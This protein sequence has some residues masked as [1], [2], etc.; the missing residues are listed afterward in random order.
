MNAAEIAESLGGRKRTDP[1]QAAPAQ[2][3]GPAVEVDA[4]RARDDMQGDSNG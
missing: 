2:T 1:G 3:P 4:S